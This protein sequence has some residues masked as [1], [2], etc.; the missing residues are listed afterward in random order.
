MRSLRTGPGVPIVGDTPDNKAAF[1]EL[2]ENRDSIERELGTEL[3]WLEL[4]D[5]KSSVVQLM[6]RGTEPTHR[7]EW[8]EQH[9]WLCEKLTAFHHAFAPRVRALNFGPDEAAPA[10]PDAEEV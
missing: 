10:P 2:L 4:P 5:A 7:E 8:P 1:R 3:E 9:K 6:R